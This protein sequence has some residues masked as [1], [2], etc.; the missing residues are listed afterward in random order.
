MFLGK[1]F[2]KKKEEQEEGWLK[3][4]RSDRRRDPRIE[5]EK[6]V[7]LEIVNSR[8]LNEQEKK[9]LLAR[10]H[11]ISVGGIRLEAAE[12]FAPESL[13]RLKI[14][15]DQLGKWIQVFGRVRWIKKIEEQRI[16]ELGL[17]FIDTPPETVLDLME[18][19][20]RRKS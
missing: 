18:H 1:I 6:E 9:Q 20:Y 8:S 16:I 11:D 5:E 2:K 3:K 7:I 19:I 14:P 10:S 13:I 4:T 12:E 17:E 15:S